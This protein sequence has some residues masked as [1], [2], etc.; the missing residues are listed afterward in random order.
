MSTENLPDLVH[1]IDEQKG[2]RANLLN[3]L[4]KKLLFGCFFFFFSGQKSR[5]FFS[6][7]LANVASTH[8]TYYCSTA[9]EKK[10]IKKHYYRTS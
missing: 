4:Y 5:C 9:A 2:K 6:G 1:Q 3:N 7:D 8:C 10:R